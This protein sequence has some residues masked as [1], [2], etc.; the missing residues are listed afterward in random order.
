MLYE[1]ILFLLFR[2][3]TYHELNPKKNAEFF[4][5][6]IFDVKK[7]ARI[8]RSKEEFLPKL[9]PIT[10]NQ[11]VLQSHQPSEDQNRLTCQLY[12]RS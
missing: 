2:K 9:N 4:V 1:T 3:L 7:N 5:D 8:D 6:I 10:H 12:C 11:R